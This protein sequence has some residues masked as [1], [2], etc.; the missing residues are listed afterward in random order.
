MASR[1]FDLPIPLSPMKQFIFGLNAKVFESIFLYWVRV[2]GF[3]YIEHK[4]NK[5]EA[6]LGFFELE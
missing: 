6:S 1:I 2:S 4:N 3:K 5:L